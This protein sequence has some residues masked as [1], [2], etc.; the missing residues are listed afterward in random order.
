MPRFAQTATAA[1]MTTNITTTRGT[2]AARTMS[3]TDTRLVVAAGASTV[4]TAVSVEASRAG[5]CIG[6][7]YRGRRRWLAVRV[8]GGGRALSG[9]PAGASA[10]VPV[11]A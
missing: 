7:R 6:P 5:S 2:K 3:A 10:F 8:P 9:S 4:G 1:T 11:A